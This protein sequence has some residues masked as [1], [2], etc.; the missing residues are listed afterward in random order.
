M[1]AL[2]PAEH[3][4]ETGGYGVKN[5]GVCRKGAGMT[6]SRDIFSQDILTNPL[7]FKKI[8]HV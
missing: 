6:I 4:S 8:K 1:A 5:A 3:G 2:R 7:T